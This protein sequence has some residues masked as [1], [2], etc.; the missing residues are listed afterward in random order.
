M[1]INTNIKKW[2]LLKLKSYCTTKETV[3]KMKR[4]LID[5]EK[6]FVIDVTDKGLI[7]KIDKQFT[8]LNSIKTKN[9][10]KK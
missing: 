2:D 5:W 3:N 8:M 9:S 10:L 6:I 4:Q 1:E 7:S